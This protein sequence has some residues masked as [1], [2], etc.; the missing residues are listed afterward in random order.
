[1]VT[2]VLLRRAR[3]GEATYVGLS[4]VR[5]G[6]QHLYLSVARA[7]LLWFPLWLLLAEAAQRRAWVQRAY[8]AVGP[9]LMAVVVLAFTSGRWVG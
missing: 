9:P 8:V 6:D 2:A 3:W 7:T 1:M 4:V 5:P